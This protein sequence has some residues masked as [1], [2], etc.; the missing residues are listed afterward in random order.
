MDIEERI[1]AKI[2][3]I[4]LK[5]KKLPFER[6]AKGRRVKE[7]WLAAISYLD[8][9]NDEQLQAFLLDLEQSGFYQ[10]FASTGLAEM[11]LKCDIRVNGKRNI[12]L[13]NNSKRMNNKELGEFISSQNFKESSKS[14]VE[15]TEAIMGAG[16]DLV[17]SFFFNAP[18]YSLLKPLIDDIKD[19]KSRIELKQLA[20]F[21]K[22][23]ENLD[24]SERSDFSVM[25]QLNDEDFTER[26]FYYISQLN[27]KKKAKICGKIG[28]AFARKKIK[29]NEFLNIIEIISRSDFGTLVQLKVFLERAFGS[30]SIQSHIKNLNFF[31]EHSEIPDYVYDEFAGLKSR[32]VS[33]GLFYEKIEFI[34][35]FPNSSIGK[36]VN[37]IP[38]KERIKVIG[39][40]EV[41]A[42]LIVYFGWFYK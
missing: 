31:A 39:K 40:F 8:K 35:D 25:I 23:F 13:N 30:Y 29:E 19:W 16:T 11:D 18:F 7:N 2:H 1:R 10:N 21:L 14:L 37:S 32:L 9:G 20:Y 26:L 12:D 5:L 22:E 34:E 3:Q 24:Q 38:L 41:E 15:K 33:L 27:D 4:M 17:T 6:M 42:F 28:V 36:D